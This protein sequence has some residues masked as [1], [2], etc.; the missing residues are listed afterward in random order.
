MTARQG[1]RPWTADVYLLF[2]LGHP[3]IFRPGD[4]ALQERGA[5]RL[6]LA[7]R[8]IGGD[9]SG[10][11]QAGRPWRGVAPKILWAFYRNAKNRE[12]AP[13]AA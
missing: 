8:P 6:G 11:G 1:H 5:D 4:L 2:C 10:R 7:A 12:G 3:D 13:L 9:V